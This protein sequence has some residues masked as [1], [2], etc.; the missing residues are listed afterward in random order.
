MKRT[1]LY[2]TASDRYLLL[3]RKLRSS[4]DIREQ[5]VLRLEIISVLD[6]FSHILSKMKYLD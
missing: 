5:H 1:D 2:E 3:D 4:T 6:A